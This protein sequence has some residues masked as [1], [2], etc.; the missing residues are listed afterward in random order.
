MTEQTPSQ[1]N[2]DFPQRTDRQNKSLHLY[3]EQLSQTLNDAGITQKMVLQAI[4]IDWS[5]DSIKSLFRSLGR[6]KY[7]IKSTSELTTK[8]LTDIYDELNR[9]VAKFGVHIP[10]PSEEEIANQQLYGKKV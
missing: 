9:I 5:A 7:G 3:C 10:F 1:T 8:Q 6:A 4:D 2:K